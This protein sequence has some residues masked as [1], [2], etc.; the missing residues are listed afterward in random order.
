MGADDELAELL[1]CSFNIAYICVQEFSSDATKRTLIQKLRG[2]RRLT[3]AVPV[4]K[5]DATPNR[6][7]EEPAARWL[8]PP[9]SSEPSEAVIGATDGLTVEPVQTHVELKPVKVAVVVRLLPIYCTLR[10]ACALFS[11]QRLAFS[12]SSR[13]SLTALVPS[14]YT[15]SPASHA[16]QGVCSLCCDPRHFL[17]A[18]MTMC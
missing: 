9:Q 16:A 13:L 15:E 8:S 4:P 7:S 14:I 10:R 18:V 11:P 2:T 1:L 5:A 17:P 6:C 3:A 12:S